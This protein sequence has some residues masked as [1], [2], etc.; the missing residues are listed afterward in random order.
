[1]CCPFGIL[2]YNYSP[3]KRQMNRILNELSTACEVRGT[4]A[5]DITYNHNGKLR[6]YKR[7]ISAHLMRFNMPN[8]VNAVM[9]HTRM[10][11]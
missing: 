8:E 7:S 11:T 1:M 10:A 9:G 3:S 5:T 2:D 6:I 4:D